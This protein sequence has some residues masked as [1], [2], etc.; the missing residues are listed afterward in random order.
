MLLI[1]ERRQRSL[2][3]YD[4]NRH[5]AASGVHSCSTD[6]GLEGSVR[7]SLY[8]LRFGDTRAAVALIAG[9]MGTNASASSPSS[10]VALSARFQADACPRVPGSCFR[11]M[12][13]AVRRLRPTRSSLR[14]RAAA[15]SPSA[16]Q[17]RCRARAMPSRS[18]TAEAGKGSWRR[19]STGTGHGAP[20]ARR[21]Q[22][23]AL[24]RS[25]R[26]LLRRRSLDST[27]S[28]QFASPWVD[29]A[30]AG[31]TQAQTPARPSPHSHLCYPTPVRCQAAARGVFVAL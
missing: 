25:K 21:R 7:S 14:R 24:G 10:A 27:G 26:P 31:P 23:S 4:G 16:L 19:V 11:P 15:P 20:R 30:S 12:S 9:L 3:C 22:G 17:A 2:H 5:A 13:S 29:R 1:R 8:R 28:R 18:R 6:G